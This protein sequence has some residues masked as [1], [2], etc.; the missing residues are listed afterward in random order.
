[1]VLDLRCTNTILDS[2]WVQ[3]V[4]ESLTG[5]TCIDT[6]ILAM[7]GSVRLCYEDVNR[8]LPGTGSS[9]DNKNSYKIPA[10]RHVTCI[11]WIHA[12]V[13]YSTQV[14]VEDVT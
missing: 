3:L 11:R 12:H 14:S 6:Y 8:G 2:S 10:H 4:S 13:P 7:Q 1:M 9:S 5:G